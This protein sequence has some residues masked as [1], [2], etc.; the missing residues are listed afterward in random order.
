[1]K[2]GQIR[3]LVDDMP[4]MYRFY[5][6]TLGLAPGFG[7]AHDAYADF[8]LGDHVGVLAL[9]DRAS[10]ATT[11]AEVDA[12]AGVGADRV[13]IAL[14]VANV[15]TTVAELTERGVAFVTPPTDRPGWG[16][17]TAH[18][19]DPEGNLLELFH[20]IPMEG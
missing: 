6:A 10:M 15:D 8:K 19:R 17:R 16:Q 4:S 20:H 11:L 2:L 12:P 3:L 14:E 7:T 9:F 5:H 13:V 18:L 1:M